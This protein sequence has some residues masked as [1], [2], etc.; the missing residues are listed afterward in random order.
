M[1][2]EFTLN[3]G[4]FS[5]FKIECDA[6]TPD[7]WATL[8]GMIHERVGYFRD[9]IGVPRGGEQLAG[10]LRCW[11][12]NNPYFPRLVVDDVWTSGA[13]I[14]RLM[15][16]RDVGFVVF[17]RRPIPERFPV[18]ALFTMDAGPQSHGP[19]PVAAVPRPVQPL[20][21]SLNGKVVDD[22]LRMECFGS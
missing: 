2:G 14:L 16:P 10:L 5:P 22:A 7:D 12:R 19:W 20:P 21:P 1:S 6:L 13:S 9:A 11:A 18:R 17:A 15:Q 3:S 4:G 8:A